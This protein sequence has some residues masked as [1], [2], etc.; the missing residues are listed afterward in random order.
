MSDLYGYPMISVIIVCHERRNFILQAIKSVERQTIS[1]DLYEIIVVKNFLDEK[2]DK[3]I[4]CL[5]GKNILSMETSGWSKLICGV[6]ASEGE[7]LCFLDDDDMFRE[8]KLENI[9]TIFNKYQ[10][11]CFLHNGYLKILE[12]EEINISKYNKS[13]ENSHLKLFDTTIDKD[14]YKAIKMRLDFN[15]SSISVKKKYILNRLE[16]PNDSIIKS[17]DTFIFY[18]MLENSL[19]IANYSEKLTFYRYHNSVSNYVNMPSQKIIES[20]INYLTLFTQSL[21]ILKENFT[22]QMLINLIDGKISSIKCWRYFIDRSFTV[23]PLLKLNAIIYL[24]KVSVRRGM[25]FFVM[26]FLKMFL[27]GKIFQKIYLE[28]IKKGI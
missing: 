20:K 21:E 9:F 19:T 18:L 7:I 12:N 1:K 10:S 13:F 28:G 4:E 15:S 27:P 22:R 6:K 24:T 23:E 5:N 3:Y 8:D 11:L 17:V 25:F 26:N 2:I 16:T 14:L